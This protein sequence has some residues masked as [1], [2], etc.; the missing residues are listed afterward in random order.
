[1]LRAVT[2]SILSNTFSASRIDQR[3]SC[4]Q[5]SGK[6]FTILT[7]AANGDAKASVKIAILNQDVRAVCF[8]RNRII[9]VID[10]PSAKGDIISIYSVRT[11]RLFESSLE[12]HQDGTRSLHWGRRNRSQRYV[13]YRCCWRRCSREEYSLNVLLPSSCIVRHQKL[14]IRYRIGSVAQLTT[15]GSV[16]IWCFRRRCLE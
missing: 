6:A 4:C 12:I 8:H 10:S 3:R 11:I 5:D 2:F 16:R 1:M 7:N 15:S 14:H 9:T 13:L